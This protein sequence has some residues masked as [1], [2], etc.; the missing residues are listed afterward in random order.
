MGVSTHW[1]DPDIAEAA[2]RGVVRATSLLLNESDQL[3]PIEEGD[4]VESGDTDVDGTRGEVY[5][6]SDHA[7]TQHEHLEYKH[8][9]GQAKFLETALVNN[10]ERLVAAM[11]EPIRDA[12]M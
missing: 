3:A 1:D 9:N 10:A 11:S 12:L 4:L 5:Y 7:I 2:H 8:P 6:D